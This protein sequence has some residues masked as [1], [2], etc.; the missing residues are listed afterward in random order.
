MKRILA[1]ALTLTLLVLVFASCGKQP[2]VINDDPVNILIKDAEDVPF[3]FYLLPDEAGI[4]SEAALFMWRD[5]GDTIKVPETITY[6]NHVYPVT[7]IGL[8][9]GVTPNP[10]GL[11]K[12]ILSKN[13][14]T[15]NDNAFNACSNLETIEFVEGLET[16]GGWAFMYANLIEIHLPESLKSI[17]PHAFSSC[18]QL[19]GVYIN[20]NIKEISK[21]AFVYCTSVEVI[22]I[23]NAFADRLAEDIFAY[24]PN[25][26]GDK[27]KVI[28][29]SEK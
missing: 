24:G 14:K 18:D 22:S 26:S 16:I 5:D 10:L 6:N 29:T 7:T 9:Q 3:Y 8:G 19:K 11:K 1:I 15:I 23:P 20:N 12:L 13:V 17:G 25:F 27:V 4:A 21:K 2:P 28:Y